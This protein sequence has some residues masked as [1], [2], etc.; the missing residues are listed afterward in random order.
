MNDDKLLR[1]LQ[2][3]EETAL[4]QLMDKY[5]RYVLT[6]IS[7]IIGSAG[8]YS[9]AEELTAD[10]FYSV[11]RHASDIA[12]GKLKAYLVV[13]ARNKAK[14]YLRGKRQLPMDLDTITLPDSETSPEAAV[15]QQDLKFQVRKA[16]GK[17]TPKDRE[18]F[19]RYYFYFQT[20]EQ[21]ALIMSIP[22]AT[23][24]SRLARGRKLLKSI[25]TQEALR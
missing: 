9:D 22:A 5:H 13:T 7:N 1:Q 14:D 17:M 24:R 12:P 4:H 8:T 21:I 20:S 3:N 6:V 11:W 15:L 23:V 2:G 18:I 10:T 25:L 19:L 16:I